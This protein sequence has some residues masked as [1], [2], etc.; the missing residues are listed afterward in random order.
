MN[1]QSRIRKFVVAAGLLVALTACS[2]QV[3][4]QVSDPYPDT[5]SVEAVAPDVRSTTVFSRG[6]KVVVVLKPLKAYYKN[7][8]EAIASGAAPMYQGKAGYRRALDKDRDGVACELESNGRPEVDP[9]VETTTTAPVYYAS[10]EIAK[11]ANDVPL[12]AGEAGYREALDPDGDGV[13]CEEEVPD[14]PPAPTPEPDT[15]PTPV[16]PSSGEATTA[17]VVSVDPGTGSVPP[18]PTDP[19]TPSE[20]VT[21]TSEPTPAPTEAP[22]PDASAAPSTGE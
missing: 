18:P 17:S 4:T 14:L 21:P 3:P 16:R 7:C 2:P 22:S 6:G 20:P 9:S 13:A 19:F 10:C 12:F 1:T 8:D 5:A 11:A 15:T